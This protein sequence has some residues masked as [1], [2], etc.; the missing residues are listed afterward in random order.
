MACEYCNRATYIDNEVIQFQERPCNYTY[1]LIGR[2][3]YFREDCSWRLEFPLLGIQ[4]EVNNCPFC[5]NR[6]DPLMVTSTLLYTF[7]K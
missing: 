7:Y 2:L 1:N 4:C 5:G 3:V 6:L